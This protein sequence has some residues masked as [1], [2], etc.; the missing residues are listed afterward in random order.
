[1]MARREPTVLVVLGNRPQFIKHAPVERA[2]AQHAPGVRVV[3]VDTGQHYDYGLAG[4]F[5]DEL[6]LGP[7]AH[8]LGV[9]SASHAEQLA[10]MLPPLEHVI[11]EERAGCVL[12]YGDTNSTLGG[13]LA[14]RSAGVPVAHVEAGLRSFDRSMPEELNRLLVDRIADDLYCPT[15]TAR[16]N[17]AAEGIGDGVH[18]VGDVM[19][20]IALLLADAADSRWARWEARGLDARGYAL[21]TAHRAANTTEESLRSLV[22]TLVSAPVPLVFPV[23]PRTEA[24]LTRLGLHVELAEAP[25][26]MLLPPIGYLDTACLLRH[27]RCLATDSGGMQKEA[28]VHGIPCITMRDTTEWVETVEAGANTLVHLSRRRI[29]G[30]LE[31]AFA[32]DPGDLPLEGLPAVYGSGDSARQIVEGITARL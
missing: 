12:V 11:R 27:A 8:S 6:E 23:H 7:P 10:R 1:M 3:T 29:H 26:V 20:D 19:A 2:F 9:G 28:Y 17:L 13:A 25:H 5:M 18:V 22:A 24:Q 30:A 14:A 4:I 31:A 21:V 16:A 15:P 32:R